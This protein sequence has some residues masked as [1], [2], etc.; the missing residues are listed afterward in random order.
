MDAGPTSGPV[1]APEVVGVLGQHVLLDGFRVIVDLARS[2]GCQLV[3]ERSGRTLLDF[4]GFYGTMAVG[5]NHPWFD[6]A[7]VKEELLE[8]A[9][10]KVANS[11]VYSR[12]YA[13]FV[14]T[15]H[16]VFGLRPLE[17]YFFIEGGTLAVENALKAAMDWKV[18]RNLARGHGERGTEIVHFE[19]A[20][21]G[22]SGYTLSLTNTDP[23]KTDYFAKFDWPR[24]PAPTLDF[25]LPEP[26][27]TWDAAARER[28]IET[29][30]SELLAARAGDIAAILI[31]PIQ[32]EGGDRHF[33]GEWLATL[34]RLCDEYGV[35]L[36]FD[37]VQ[38]GA[39]TT[40]RNW[41]CEHFGVLP[42]LLAFGKKAQ[43]CGV[44]AGPRLDEVPENVFRVPSRINSTW[45]GN[46]ADMVR[47]MHTL[48]LIEH[49]GLVENARDM[50]AELLAGLQ[51]L[52]AEEPL[53]TAP[54]GRG[55]MVA[56]DLPNPE[57]RDRFYTS[58][59]ESGLLT[60]RSGERSIRFRPPLDV[61]A[62]DLREALRIV[63]EQCR[64][65]GAR[66]V[67]PPAP[68]AGAEGALNPS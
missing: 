19:R 46:L 37:E 62:P 58:L 50:G 21:H 25:T 24:L 42:D 39:G 43:V 54:R 14:K 60:L 45:G 66:P 64:R 2:R 6:R 44:M 40:G 7:E 10:T 5:F 26:T 33:R 34:R 11:D 23:R 52:A 31:E 67:S 56:F 63:R 3:D 59:F 38:T 68:E 53:L 15:F 41:C 35:L 18:R 29:Q 16:A 47:A 32:G 65:N 9:R 36:V 20:F 1:A 57:Q 51:E 55:L 12:P 13:T 4:Y 61:T 30:L 17:R 8:A 48:R 27:R 22:R 28:R 49:D